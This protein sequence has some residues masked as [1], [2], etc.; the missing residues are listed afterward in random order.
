MHLVQLIIWAT[1]LDV[2]DGLPLKELQKVWKA[3]RR[4]E[5]GSMNMS[6]FKI[7]L[8]LSIAFLFSNYRIVEMDSLCAATILFQVTL[9][10]LLF[11]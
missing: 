7:V 8:L 3:L 6:P 2:V 11:L 10:S 9:I 4:K 5:I 1:V